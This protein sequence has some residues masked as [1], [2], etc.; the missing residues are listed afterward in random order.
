MRPP[1]RTRRVLLGL[2]IATASVS[3][4][5]A[6]A[7]LAALWS[8]RPAATFTATGGELRLRGPGT[9]IIMTDRPTRPVPTMTQALEPPLREAFEQALKNAAAALKDVPPGETATFN[10][11]ASFSLDDYMAG[12]ATIDGRFGWPFASLGSTRTVRYGT[13]DA[14]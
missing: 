8:D 7:W 4:A 13:P 10:A 5:L 12:E 14:S 9:R 3:L 2:D 1:S 6:S 11:A